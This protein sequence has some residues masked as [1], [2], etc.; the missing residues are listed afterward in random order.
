[1][2]HCILPIQ[3]CYFASD[4]CLKFCNN[5]NNIII[6]LKFV[7]IIILFKFFLSTFSKSIKNKF[8]MSISFFKGSFIS[9]KIIEKVKLGKFIGTQGTS[10]VNISKSL[11]TNWFFFIKK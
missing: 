7:E 2:G 8:F 3:S 6:L 11:Q 4:I 10:T 5:K 9:Y 1:M